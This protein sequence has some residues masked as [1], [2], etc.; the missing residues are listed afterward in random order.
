MPKRFYKHKLLSDENMPPRTQSPR[1]NAHFDVKHVSHDYHKDGI[2]DEE[3]YALAVE[4]GRIIITINRDDFEKLAGTKADC[5]VIAVSDGPAAV[6]TD[7]KL[8]ALL[9]RHGPTY[10]R[11]RVV[12]LGA[13]DTK[14]KAL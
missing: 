2:P 11:G 4:Q 3:V 5:G 1:L 8:T 6:R 13:P 7:T 9:M 14:T 10:F 12:P